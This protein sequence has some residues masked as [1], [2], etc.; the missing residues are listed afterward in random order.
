MGQVRWIWGRGGKP[1]MSKYSLFSQC[2]SP[3]GDDDGLLPIPGGV[4]SHNLGMGGDILRRELRGLVWLGVNPPQRFHFL[5]KREMKNIS[6][7]TTSHMAQSAQGPKASPSTWPQ[8]RPSPQSPTSTTNQGKLLLDL[9]VP[10]TGESD[11]VPTAGA[12]TQL[13]LRYSCCGSCPGR[14]TV[15]C[16]PH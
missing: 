5:T 6:N 11:L 4:V 3:A 7:K 14:C 2:L 8:I 10:V 15:W 12:D 1:E 9:R 13:T 16:V